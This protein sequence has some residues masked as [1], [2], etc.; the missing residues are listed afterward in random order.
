MIVSDN[1]DSSGS[2]MMMTGMIIMIRNYCAK[3]SL[4]VMVKKWTD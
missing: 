2:A 4:L 1:S 3:K